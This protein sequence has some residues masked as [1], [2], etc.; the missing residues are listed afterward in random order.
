MRVIGCRAMLCFHCAM[1][2]LNLEALGSDVR[3]DVSLELL[4]R[5]RDGQVY[6][7]QMRF[8]LPMGSSGS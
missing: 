1:I 7:E 4:R 6:D 2:S 5:L 3:M 8:Y